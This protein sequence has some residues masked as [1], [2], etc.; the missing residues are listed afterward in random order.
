MAP[1]AGQTLVR[2]S[3]AQPRAG[4]LAR[5]LACEVLFPQLGRNGAPRAL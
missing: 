3:A 1:S 4:R 5:D 2:T